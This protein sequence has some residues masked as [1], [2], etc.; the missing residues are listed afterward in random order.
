M[1][2]V[3]SNMLSPFEMSIA[4]Q[5]FAASM[6]RP[7]MM[8]MDEHGVLAGWKTHAELDLTGRSFDFP[9][10]EK[11]HLAFLAA[12]FRE[13]D[14]D[15]DGTLD[16]EELH[17]ALVGLGMPAEDGDV[18]SLFR[19]LDSNADQRIQLSEWLDN[20]PSTLQAKLADHA[21]AVCWR[22]RGQ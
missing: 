17:S 1:G 18:Q 5:K 12:A 16:K 11:E 21:G 2:T 6:E 8:L 22:R 19:M 4:A 20:I 15:S 9:R 14:L 7:G 3:M 10:T 13:F